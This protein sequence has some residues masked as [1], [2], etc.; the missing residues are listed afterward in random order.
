MSLEDTLSIL[1]SIYSCIGIVIILLVGR[2]KAKLTFL[3]LLDST[4]LVCTFLLNKI[5]K[6]DILFFKLKII[7][8][9]RFSISKENNLIWQ[10]ISD[11]IQSSFE[12]PATNIAELKEHTTKTKGN[13]FEVFC[14]LYLLNAYDYYIN[15]RLLSEV[16]NE[17]LEKLGMKR[18]DVGIDLIAT[19]KSNNYYAIQ[20][21]YRI[22]TPKRKNVLSWKQ[23]STFYSLCLRTGPFY[24]M[25]VMTNAD[26]VKREGRKTASD[27]SICYQT[28]N[29]TDRLTWCKILGST[30]YSL[31]PQGKLNEEEKEMNSDER[32][33]QNVKINIVI[34][35]EID[36][37]II[38]NKESSISQE[39]ENLRNLRNNFLNK[40]NSKSENK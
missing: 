33:N 21:K 37:P 38:S 23:L 1:E 16:P 36:I 22:G 13:I 11:R 3:N 40:L 5:I 35:K 7:K 24:K 20:C 18:A 17:I 19:D 27:L 39:K 2:R 34:K 26:Y 25:I 6:L 29:N 28:F 10:N 30:G 12:K 4:E 8:L 15:V 32:R 9:I 31:A 14:K